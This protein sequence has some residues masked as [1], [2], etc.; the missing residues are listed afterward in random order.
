[1]G[2][3]G[4][5][6]TASTMIRHQRSIRSKVM[7]L[8]VAAVMIVMALHHRSV[9]TDALVRELIQ[10]SSA[11]LC[12]SAS[13][14]SLSSSDPSATSTR[15]AY[16]QSFGLFDDVTDLMWS[17]IRKRV[18]S[19][20]WYWNPSNP[21]FKVDDAPWWHA[22]NMLP[23][24]NCPHQERIGSKVH[25][26]SKFVCNAD[27]LVHENKPDCLIYSIG[28]AGD[29]KFEDAIAQMH[30]GKCEIHVFDP[31]NWERKGDVEN[32]NIHYH[33]WG[34]VSTYDKESK[35]VVWPK[36]RGGGFKTFPDTLKELGHENRTIDIFKIDCEG[37]EYST[38]KDWITHGMFGEK[39]AA[40]L[41]RCFLCFCIVLKTLLFPF[42]MYT[43]QISAN[44]ISKCTEFP[45]QVEIRRRGGLRNP[46]IWPRIIT[47]ILPITDL[48]SLVEIQTTHLVSNCPLSNYIPTFGKPMMMQVP[49]PRRSNSA[50]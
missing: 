21:L 34:F 6:K 11:S 48:H 12:M 37:C 31:A 26:G 2:S 28:S 23:N 4:L 30:K 18:L 38:H 29:F 15:L 40:T 20:S 32:K 22:H 25:E 27:R 1:M 5:D 36:G 46:W 47:R 39:A 45:N 8:A 24:F 42:L 19:N 14:A 44:S 3:D 35:S 16:E 9:S 41:S 43:L 7:F 33:V 17:R 10:A 49:L 50:M 13:S